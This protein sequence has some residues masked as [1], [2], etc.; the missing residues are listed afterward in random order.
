MLN[1]LI[2]KFWLI[3]PNGKWWR[4]RDYSNTRTQHFDMWIFVVACLLMG[5]MGCCLALT[6]KR[7]NMC[8]A[9]KLAGK[10]IICMRRCR[11]YITDYLVFF[12]RSLLFFP[13]Y[14][15]DLFIHEMH[16]FFFLLCVLVYSWFFSV[17]ISKLIVVRS[18]C[19]I[20]TYLY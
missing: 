8:A 2:K 6:A 18:R 3:K 19:W 20:Y 15:W 1:K 10:K 11:C 9:A 13:L 14:S 17:D 7:P 5:S 4:I 16:L 12:G